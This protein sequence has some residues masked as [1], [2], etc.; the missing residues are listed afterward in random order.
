M[1][2]GTGEV[3]NIRSKSSGTAVPERL[4]RSERLRMVL[5]RELTELQRYTITAYYFQGMTLKQIARKRNVNVSTVCRT[6]HRAE[7]KIKRF[8]SY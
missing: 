1:T 6:L 5:H 8:L 3:T 7:Q 2:G 4:L